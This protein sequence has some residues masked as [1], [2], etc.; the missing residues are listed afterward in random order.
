[1][2]A[3]FAADV[4]TVR[5]SGWV[6]LALVCSFPLQVQ[7]Q[8]PA[9]DGEPG[10][11]ADAEEPEPTAGPEEPEPVEGAD[12]PLM[13]VGTPTGSIDVPPDP[14]GEILGAVEY[15]R[16]ETERSR[17]GLIAVGSLTN[18]ADEAAPEEIE[19]DEELP[20]YQGVI[21]GAR[22][23][24]EPFDDYIGRK[25]NYVTWVGYEPGPDRVFIQLTRPAEYTLSRGS[26][27]ELFVDVP[28]AR[29]A[30]RN[31]S[32]PLDLAFF[33]TVVAKVRARKLRGVG[34]RVVIT[35]KEHSTYRLE[36][37]GRYIYVYFRG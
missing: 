36:R 11:T 18:P 22:E 4:D 8:E 7:A 2:H 34:V 14:Q 33:P 13:G 20:A 9:D 35:L 19:L 15:R 32:R 16:T 30:T 17:G 10:A 23:T 1:V 25:R 29:I 6:V 12:A 5:S 28:D 21:P 27:G 31:N 37:K 26:K 3:R 24:A